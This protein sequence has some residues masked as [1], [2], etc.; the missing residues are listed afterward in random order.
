MTRT[1]VATDD[2]GDALRR[3]TE[4]VLRWLADDLRAVAATP[5]RDRTQPDDAHR[6]RTALALVEAELRRRAHRP[7]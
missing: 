6:A 4:P 1:A 5:H 7:D 2:G 3:A